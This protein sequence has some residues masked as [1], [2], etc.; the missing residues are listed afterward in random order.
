ML[1]LR[2]LPLLLLGALAFGGEA[3]EV[4]I[5]L[6]RSTDLTKLADLVAHE[7]GVSLQYP[8]RA[9]KG[10]VVLSINET[11]DA[12]RLWE[13]F[14]QVLASQNFT[15]VVVGDPPVFEVVQIAQAASRSGVLAAETLAGMRF[16]PGYV[17]QV[18][19]LAHMGADS[20]VQALGAVFGG[21]EAQVKILDK[22]RGQVVLAGVRSRLEDA[23]R[24]LGFLDQPG[25]LP[26]IRRYVPER[27]APNA[28]QAAAK[29]AWTA[30]DR[31][32]AVQ[33]QVEI[34]LTPDQRQLLLIATA[35][36]VDDLE[37]LV[38]ELDE[39]EPVERRSY[40]PEHYGVDDVAPLL[41][42]LMA[43]RRGRR[44]G[45]L[46]I[47][48][49]SLTGTLIVDATA[50]QHERIAAVIQELDD[51]PE[52]AR[53]QVRH[54]VV[55][56][57]PVD[58]LVDILR[59]M[60]QSGLL[61]ARVP[62]SGPA[63]P[64]PPAAEGAEAGDAPPPSPP[65]GPATTPSRSGGSGEG[66]VRESLVIATDPSTS[67][68][69]AMGEPRLLAQLA[70]LLRELDVRQPQ[71]ELE[72]IMVSLSKGQ[73]RDL[74]VEL[75]RAFQHRQTTFLLS[76][77]FGLG[78]IDTAFPAWATATA[79]SAATTT[80]TVP[81][82]A[83]TITTDLTAPVPAPVPLIGSSPAGSGFNGAV[84]NPGDFASVV[85][86]LETVTDGESLIRAR[87]VVNNN[88]EASLNGVVQE[89][90]SSINTGNTV[91][92]TSFGG[93]SDAGTEVG[94]TPQIAAGD[95]V[96]LDYDI[97]QSSFL[98]N[99]VV[100][101]DGQIVPPPKRSDTVSST[102]TIPDNYVIAIGGL[103]SETERWSE[104]R[105]PVLGQIPWL[106]HLFKSTSKSENDTRFYV[107]IRANILRPHG[108]ED[109]KYLSRDRLDEAGLP[110]RVWPRLKA[111]FI[112]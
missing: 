73:T 52:D 97:S 104:S 1:R 63:V 40:R 37:A 28:L 87:I 92:T 41:E 80:L 31:V 38:I 60:A 34:H 103:S 85:R 35:D 9:L 33:R 22:E 90:F 94:I 105:L 91:A 95:H 77:L 109:L 2:F 62:Q 26:A 43:P 47:V 27:A 83:G 25:K 53:R 88:A 69:I 4:G 64:P 45:D 15:T 96:T 23:R 100:G 10:E 82:G 24:L 3:D 5:Q 16:K 78:G 14:N 61:D 7:V 17:V 110:D 68:I 18:H 48:R 51:A 81:V 30:M 19:E 71:V 29:A 93:T 74:G 99:S 72:V 8:A 55:R 11:V 32:G 107:F 111:R 67:T 98:G 6:P 46:R 54:F 101:A 21:R 89:P 56:N 59:E 13:L 36:V 42:Q 65:P 106:G 57:R 75:F 44:Q 12:D 58:E 49:D 20:A 66:Q 112:E 70:D 84:I 39:S 79:D 76:S 108:F 50:A 86:A 102:A